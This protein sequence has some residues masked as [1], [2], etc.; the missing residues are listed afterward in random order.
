MI[1]ELFLIFLTYK[2]VWGKDLLHACVLLESSQHG[3]AKYFAF[4]TDVIEHT[5]K[6]IENRADI[7]PEYSLALIPK[8]TQ[9]TPFSFFFYK[10]ALCLYMHDMLKHI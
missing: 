9:V 3:M 7:L 8:D 6:E 10:T 5:F 2:Y 4:F 1:L